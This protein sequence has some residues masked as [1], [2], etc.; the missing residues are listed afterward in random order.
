MTS[1]QASNYY[2]Q[3]QIEREATPQQI[4]QAFRKLALK[5]HPDK[6]DGAE[7]AV[8]AFRAVAEAYEVLSSPT[9]RAIYDQYEEAGLKDGVPD[10]R[11][12][13]IGG[14]YRF[15]GDAQRIFETFFGSSS[16]FGELYGG[17]ADP[18]S[19]TGDA[20]EP[21]FFGELTSLAKPVTAAQPRPIMRDISVTLGQLYRGDSLT[22]PHLRKKLNADGVTTTTLAEE[23]RLQIQPGWASG[24]KVRAPRARR[25]SASACAARSDA[26]R[27]RLGAAARARTGRSERAA[28]ADVRC[29]L[30]LRRWCLQRRAT[31]GPLP[32]PPMWSSRSKRAVRATATAVQATTSSTRR[33]LRSRCALDRARGRAPPPCVPTSRAMCLCLAARSSHLAIACAACAAVPPPPLPRLLPCAGRAVRIDSAG[34]HARW[35]HAF[36]GTHRGH[37]AGIRQGR[38]GRGHARATAASRLGQKRRGRWRG[39]PHGRP[40]DRV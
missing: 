37:S 32:C 1:V 18:A 7:E 2:A 26:A 15:S 11:G 23:L 16:P 21:A 10:G 36:S 27:P 31:R 8:L 30:P 6:H 39:W 35:A 4:N 9:L 20:A 3:L 38:A 5:H 28:R 24:Y 40:A 29:C 33:A 13:L 25:D 17:L 22:V 12:G 14:T 19:S 34:A